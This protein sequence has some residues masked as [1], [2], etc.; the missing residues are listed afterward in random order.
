MSAFALPPCFPAADGRIHPMWPIIAMVAGFALWWPLGLAVL[1]LWRGPG[2]VGPHCTARLGRRPRRPFLVGS[3]NSAF[4][5][6]RVA[7]LARLDSE[8]RA[9]D[10]QQRDFGAFLDQ[11][12]RARDR[13]EFDRFMD[14]RAR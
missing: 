3:G 2:L 11:L 1:A 13:E 10:D 8:R 4:D 6:H 14:G 9:L 7:V 12:K 5:A